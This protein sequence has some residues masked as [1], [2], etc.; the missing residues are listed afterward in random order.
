MKEKHLVYM[1]NHNV[2][3]KYFTLSGTGSAWNMSLPDKMKVNHQSEAF[4]S[5]VHLTD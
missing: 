2:T 3:L 1:P 4:L 5:N